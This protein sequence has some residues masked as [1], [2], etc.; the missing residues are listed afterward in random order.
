MIRPNR[1][2]PPR[3]AASGPDAHD[4][5]GDG[6]APT[7]GTCYTKKTLA[8]YLGVS[9]RTLDRAAAIGL[10]PT[11]DLLV[12]ARPGGA[13]A[14]SRSGSHSTPDSPAERGSVMREP[15]EQDRDA[16]PC[17]SAE[18][19][20]DIRDPQH[21]FHRRMAPRPGL[22]D[23]V[24]SPGRYYTTDEGGTYLRPD[25]EADLWG[26]V[27]LELKTSRSRRHPRPTRGT[28]RREGLAA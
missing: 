2:A 12:G 16:R 17:N 18:P 22:E 13:P 19:G 7:P 9:T 3:G 24:L 20:D 26:S 10:L 15:L 23:E 25:D 28:D 27:S 1:P 4:G 21:Y 11:P 8:I 14:P 5:L 6:P